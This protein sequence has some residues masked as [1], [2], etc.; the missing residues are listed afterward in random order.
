MPRRG[1]SKTP[2]Q[3]TPSGAESSGAEP[4]PQPAPLNAFSLQSP[5]LG[6]TTLAEYSTG[7]TY[8]I[9]VKLFKWGGEK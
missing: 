7:R 5:L 6:K 2:S 8:F 1:R 3:R 4:V 9:G